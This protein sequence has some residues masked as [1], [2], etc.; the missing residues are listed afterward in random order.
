MPLSDKESA[1]FSTFYFVCLSTVLSLSSG[2]AI[3]LADSIFSSVYLGA[4]VKLALL[5]GVMDLKLAELLI[6]PLVFLDFVTGLPVLGLYLAFAL[7]AAVA[8]TPE[9]WPQAVPPIREF[10]F[11]FLE[12]P[13][14]VPTLLIWRWPFGDDSRL[15]PVELV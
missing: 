8:S 15:I 12:R 11:N 9:L 14:G 13:E 7:V 1:S 5:Q 3:E 10:G 6:A 4:R 2:S